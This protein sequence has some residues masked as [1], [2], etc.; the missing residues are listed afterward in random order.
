IADKKGNYVT[1][2]T[3]DEMIIPIWPE[4][5]FAQEL[6]KTEWRNC[7]VKMVELKEFM[8]WMDK[9]ESENYLFGG[10]PNQK[11]NSIVVKPIEIK[12]HLIFECQQYE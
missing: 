3:V 1:C 5:E 12:N 7:V 9:L 11:L 2:G 10:F 4:L 6:I 8:K